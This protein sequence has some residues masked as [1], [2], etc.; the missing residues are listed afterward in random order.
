MN[1][2]SNPDINTESSKARDIE[3]V[4]K[5]AE[6]EVSKASHRARLEIQECLVALAHG[7]KPTLEVK[8]LTDVGSG[9]FEM[10]TRGR[11]SFRCVFHMKDAGK[12]VVVAVREKAKSGPL[13]PLIDVVR[14]RLKKE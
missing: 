14:K 3:P 11:P 2:D 7:L 1:D 4:S 9:V 10:K 6:R 13:R 5:A 8:P 12:I